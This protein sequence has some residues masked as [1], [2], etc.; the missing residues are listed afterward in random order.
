MHSFVF[1]C[2]VLDRPCESIRWIGGARIVACT[3]RICVDTGSS[4]WNWRDRLF[5]GACGVFIVIGHVSFVTDKR[6]GIL[7][8]CA[9]NG[10]IVAGVVALGLY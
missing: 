7:V 8:C 4:G 10:V 3:C 1:L 2:Q 6:E 5:Y 9:I